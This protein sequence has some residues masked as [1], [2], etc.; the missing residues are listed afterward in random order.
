M[1]RP[2]PSSNSPNLHLVHPTAGESERIS[3]NTFGSWGDSFKI[4]DYLKES[5]YLTTIPL[6]SDSGQ[7]NW[8]LVDKNLAPDQR[9]ILCSCESF[10][11][12]AL[13]SDAKGRV[14]EAIIHGIASVFCFPE[15]RGL[16]YVA[17]HMRELGMRLRDWQSEQAP[18]IGSV[19]YSDIGKLFY[20]KLGWIPNDTNMHIEFSPEK[21]PNRNNSL[22][23]DVFECNLAALCERDEAMVRTAMKTA[24]PGVQ[25][26][27]V[28]LPDIDHMLW[29]IRKEEFA[30]KNLFGKTPRAKGAI[31]GPPGRQVWA[32]W[33]H[34][35]YGRPDAAS[36][37]NVLYILRLVVEGDDS[38][39]GPPTSES[40]GPDRTLPA[41]QT[42]S[43][44]AV[45]Q[46][47]KNEAAEWQLNCVKLWEPSPC[48][49][50][51]IGSGMIDHTIVER[52]E[53]SIASG[54]W[55]NDA[56]DANTLPVWIN[57]EYYAWV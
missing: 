46:A 7:T 13:T 11:K 17:R 14:E 23:Q 21:M 19:L 50:K 38:R 25:K 30:T 18:V 2:I 22:A 34:R 3:I 32:I 29:H 45:L 57:N 48:V 16:G 53:D 49:R 39:K 36:P 52:E 31:A 1:E 24:A 47:A 28:V 35:Y 55:Y 43:L 26:R 15:H 41:D 12:R 4:A 10:K 20:A 56:D 54:M 42:S 27:V 5:L 9:E 8:I 6:A 33:T 44:R 40:S 51:A 37:S